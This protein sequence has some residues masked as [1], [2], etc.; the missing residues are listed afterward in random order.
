MRGLGL[1]KDLILN[2]KEQHVSQV[3]AVPPG[4][5]HINFLS[6]AKRSYVASD[7]RI[8]V[9]RVNNFEFREAQ[10]PADKA[11]GLQ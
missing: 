9:F 8:F 2:W 3:I 6:D 4:I 10:E 7:P 1:S 5:Y 11:T